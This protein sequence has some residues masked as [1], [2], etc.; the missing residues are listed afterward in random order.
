[1]TPMVNRDRRVVAGGAKG[2]VEGGSWPTGPKT[3]TTAERGRLGQG[4]GGRWSV[5][6]VA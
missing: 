3:R 1:M 2:E 5:A 6:G 4:L